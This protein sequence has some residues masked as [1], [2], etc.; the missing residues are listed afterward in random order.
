MN[1]TKLVTHTLISISVLLMSSCYYD[2][3]VI[4]DTLVEDTVVSFAEDIQPVLNANCASCHPLL[5]PELDLTVGNSYNAIIGGA[6]VIPENVDTSPLYQRLLGNPRIMPPSGALPSQEIEIIK[7]WIE[8]GAN[9][10]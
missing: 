4:E 6:Y 8:Q 2:E 5:V 9:N 3:L 1:R 7:R 10:N